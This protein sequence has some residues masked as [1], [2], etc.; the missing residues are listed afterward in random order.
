MTSDTVTQA[1]IDI[2]SAI[3]AAATSAGSVD[4][5]VNEVTQL[6]TAHRRAAVAELV[7]AIEQALKCTVL[8]RDSQII[9]DK[10]DPREILR[11]A[12]SRHRENSNG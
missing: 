8:V 4:D 10:E 3:L 9:F 2:A 12:L 11:S 7:E 6:A 5:K 1:D